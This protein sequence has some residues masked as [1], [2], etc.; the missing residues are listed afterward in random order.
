[1]QAEIVEPTIEDG[2]SPLEKITLKLSKEGGHPEI[3][4]WPNYTKTPTS[5]KRTLPD[6]IE[7]APPE[8]KKLKIDAD[9]SI[10]LVDTD[11]TKS[12]DK[13]VSDDVTISRIA[14]ET[15]PPEGSKLK[16]ILL[17][18]NRGRMEFPDFESSSS[19]DVRI[20]QGVDPLAPSMDESSSQDVLVEEL[21]AEAD[22]SPKRRGRPRKTPLETR[23]ELKDE[24]VKIDLEESPQKVE[25]EPILVTPV[26]EPHGSEEESEMDTSFPFT[27]ISPRGSRGKSYR[28]RRG[29]GGRGSRGGRGAYKRK[30][31]EVI[32]LRCTNC[33]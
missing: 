1:M 7:P 28:S 33:V 15:K 11:I 12:P 24:E 32:D 6:M 26:K 16:D 31:E 23:T 13:A 20:V 9:I 27:P 2:T 29:R 10:K 21:V 4:H 14:S 8:T 19:D 3:L 17:K 22:N 30:Q 18:Y 25:E 5:S